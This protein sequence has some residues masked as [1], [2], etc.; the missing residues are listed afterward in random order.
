MNRLTINLEALR[1]NINTIDGWLK[2]HGATWTL[3][4]KVLCGHRD[5]LAALQH[6]GVHSMADS[7]LR[8]LRNIVKLT[9]EIET[10][11]L[12]LP[13]MAAIPQIIELTDA[14]LNSEIE[15]IEALSA[16]ACRQDRRHGIIVMIELGD[17]REGILPGHLIHFY[18][19]IFELPNLEVLGI[20]ANIGCLSGCVPN[21]DQYTQL[22]LYR[23]LLELKFGRELPMISAGTSATLPLLHESSVPKAINHFRV[24]DSVFLGTDLIHGGAMAELRDD[25]MLLEVDVVEIKEKSLVPVGETS[26]LAPF[27][28]TATEEYEPGARGYRAICTVGGLDTDV[29]G[30]TPVDT[31]YSIAGG[32]S[33][34]T[35]INIGDNRGDLAI[36]DQIKLRPNYAALLRLMVSP[37]IDKEVVPPLDTFVDRAERWDDPGLPPVIDA[38]GAGAEG[39]G[40]T[41]TDAGP[42]SAT[43]E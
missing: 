21:V 8:N 7:R 16:E 37:Y 18:N 4:T 31:R 41:G 1:H 15:T 10:W 9:P 5:T 22:K 30:L 29:A 14:S 12:R 43:H 38:D 2:D 28:F 33:D 3:V 42:K 32:A 34:L 36:G 24:G 6:L 35:V 39:A 20:G 40:T 17:L 11:Y 25:A 26:S 19:H 27:E 13:H 23:E